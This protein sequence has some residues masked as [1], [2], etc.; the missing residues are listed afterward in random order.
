MR[1][2]PFGKTLAV[3]ALAIAAIAPGAR[4][5]DRI[6]ASPV[7]AAS[8]SASAEALRPT[9]VGALE[10]ASGHLLVMGRRLAVE[11][12]KGR[13]V[14]VTFPHEAPK[15]VER[16]VALA[17]DGFYDGLAVHRAVPGFLFQV[18]DPATR[19]GALDPAAAY[20]GGSGQKLPPEYD[21]QAL[22]QLPGVVGLARGKAPDSGDSQFYVLFRPAPQLEGHF[23]AWGLVVEGLPVAA[24]LQ[25]GDR[26]TRLRPVPL[27]SPSPSPTRS[28]RFGS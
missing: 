21:E 10:A 1:P 28:K 25:A 22:A 9:T 11:T 20:T 4:A 18:G 8:P 17:E 27:P 2:G 16:L 12:P 24:S 15:T 26:I 5:Q 23:T 6:I 19:Q 13:F 14:I 3:L 7:P